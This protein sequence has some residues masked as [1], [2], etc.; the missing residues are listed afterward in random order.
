MAIQEV[1]QKQLELL[2]E[3]DQ[4]AI[5]ARFRDKRDTCAT[6]DDANDLMLSLILDHL[7]GQVRDG[8]LSTEVRSFISHTHTH[9]LDLPSLPRS[10]KLFLW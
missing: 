2:S 3:A 9:T 7:N 6:D 4:D 1:L 5:E 10:P 8:A